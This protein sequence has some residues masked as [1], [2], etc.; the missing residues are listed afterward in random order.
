MRSL[1]SVVLRVLAHH[2]GHPVDAIHPWQELEHDLDMTP[3]EIVLVALEVEGIVDADL[4][5]TDLARVRSVGDLLTFFARETARAHVAL[6][7][8]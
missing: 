5:V 3:L 7:V 8:A 4:D 6:D 1:R 2:S